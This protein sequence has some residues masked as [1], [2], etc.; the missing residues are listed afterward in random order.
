MV[1][2]MFAGVLPC[3]DCPGISTH[4]T[5]WKDGKVAVTSLYQDRGDFSDTEW[6]KWK[7]DGSLIRVA[8]PHDSLYYRIKS[9]SVIAMVDRQG[10]EV[11]STLRDHYL[12]RKE[13]ELNIH[14]FHGDYWLDN[15]DEQDKGYIQNLSIQ[16]LSDTEANVTVSYSKGSKGCTFVGKGTLVNNQ[17]EVP[18][19]KVDAGL[20][21]TLVV[22][23]IRNRVVSISTSRQADIKDLASFCTGGMSLLGTY[24]KQDT[25]NT[26][27]K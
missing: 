20:K 21:S 9:D 7:Q 1:S 26:S 14:D 17:L 16:P 4:V 5:F 6:G 27:K 23:F 15:K 2:G 19:D 22:R 10:K 13:P 25:A 12:L 24:T 3:A 8:M 11:D 18:L